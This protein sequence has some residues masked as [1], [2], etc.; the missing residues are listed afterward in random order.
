MKKIATVVKDDEYI[1][2]YLSTKEENM[3][4]MLPAKI[5]EDYNCLDSLFKHILELQFLG[6]QIIF[7]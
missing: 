7:K 1:K 6:Y 5:N 2:I 4:C 3:N